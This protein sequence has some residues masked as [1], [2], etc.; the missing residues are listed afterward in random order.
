MGGREGGLTGH[1]GTHSVHL[2]E[3]ALDMLD[4]PLDHALPVEGDR[5][6]HAVHVVRLLGLK[7]DDLAHVRQRGRRPRRAAAHTRLAAVHELGLGRGHLRRLLL[8]GH[9][10]VQDRHDG[11][12]LAWVDGV[13]PLQ[14]AILVS[15][16]RAGTLHT[17]AEG[18]LTALKH[19]A[20]R[21]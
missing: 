15:S 10:V 5:L 7:V 13:L 11:R 8:H 3:G 14:P 21:T 16:A 4:L 19:L 2:L 6:T 20:R 9:V 18:R 17:R 12:R 1:A